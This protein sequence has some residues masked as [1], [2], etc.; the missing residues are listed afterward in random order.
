MCSSFWILRI[1]TDGKHDFLIVH[2]YYALHE[3]N[4]WYVLRIL[5]MFLIKVLSCSKPLYNI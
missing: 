4:A 2:S 3:Q 5:T 1:Q